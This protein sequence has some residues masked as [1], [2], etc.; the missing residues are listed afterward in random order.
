MAELLSVNFTHQY[1]SMGDVNKDATVSISL[2]AIQDGLIKTVGANRFAVLV[3]IVSYIHTDGKAYLSQRKLAELTGQ[4]INTIT[5]IV[6]EL[7][8]VEYQGKKILSRELIGTTRKKSVYTVGDALV[9]HTTEVKEEPVVEGT[10][11]DAQA[12]VIHF[13]KAYQQKFNAEYPVNWSRDKGIA[14]NKLLGKFDSDETLL[15]VI[16]YAVEH[17]QEKWANEKYPLPTISMLSSWLGNTAYTFMSK[18]QQESLKK[19]ERIETAKELDQ[20]DKAFSLFD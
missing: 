5:K 12:V 18:D 8:E 14:K 4:S 15:K 2:E 17:Y 10:P 13:M 7:L 6:N 9:T 1:T 11:L 19:V 20:T 16:D 3:A